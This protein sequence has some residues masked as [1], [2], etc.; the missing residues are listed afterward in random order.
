M[1]RNERESCHWKS[2]QRIND[3]LEFLF[4][5]IDNSKVDLGDGTIL[6]T[7]TENT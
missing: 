6:E 4:L 1:N 7:A 3:K 2:Q 5:F